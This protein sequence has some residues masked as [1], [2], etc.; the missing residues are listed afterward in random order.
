MYWAQARN[1][2]DS[3]NGDKARIESIY[4]GDVKVVFDNESLKSK[5]LL[6]APFP[7][8]LAYIVDVDVETIDGRPAL[9]KV[10]ALHGTISRDV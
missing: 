10:L 4:K 5:L 9:Y 8:S 6:E 1:S 2:P 7:F 3:K